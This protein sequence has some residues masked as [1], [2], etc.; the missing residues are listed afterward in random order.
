MVSPPGSRPHFRTRSVVWDHDL[1]AQLAQ[2]AAGATKRGGTAGCFSCQLC[3]TQGR[4]ALRPEAA[5]APAAAQR[6][7]ISWQRRRIW[8]TGADRGW[9]RGVWLTDLQSRTVPW[10]CKT[11]T[12]GQ[13]GLAIAPRC[14]TES[15]INRVKAGTGARLQ[16]RAHA[17]I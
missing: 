4:H 7:M 13:A 16:T 5:S 1:K 2:A 9:F 17:H 14:C 10:L 6:S 12:P 3:A 11:C 8:L 15:L